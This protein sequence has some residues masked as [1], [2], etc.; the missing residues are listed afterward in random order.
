MSRWVWYVALGF[1]LIVYLSISV[2]APVESGS[3]SRWALLAGGALFLGCAAGLRLMKDSKEPARKAIL[4][5]ATTLMSLGVL[6]WLALAQGW[7]SYDSGI[8]AIAAGDYERAEAAFARAS[9]RA[10]SPGFSLY[11]LE[12]GFGARIGTAG[13]VFYPQ[14][15]AMAWQAEAIYGTGD[16]DA[17]RRLMRASIEL[18]RAEGVDDGTLDELEAD[19]GKMSGSSE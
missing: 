9:S 7:W 3:S 19:F 13:L 14:W 5:A 11:R 6:L 4:G 17:A 2:A 15:D 18:A 16:S 8:R 12:D 1:A 10:A